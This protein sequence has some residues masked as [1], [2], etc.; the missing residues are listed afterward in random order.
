MLFDIG[1][2][3]LKIAVFDGF[4]LNLINLSEALDIIQGQNPDS[5]ACLLCKTG[6]HSIE[7][8]LK[9]AS[10]PVYTLN[11]KRLTSLLVS[12]YANW[13]SLGQDRIA[14]LSAA[15]DLYHP[16]P[17]LLI[18]VGTCI[19]IDFLSNGTFLGGNISP[20][21]AMRLKAMHEHTTSL[22]LLEPHKMEKALGNSTQ[23]AMQIGAYQSIKA[24]ILYYVD[25]FQKNFEGGRVILS[26]GDASLF[27]LQTDWTIF[28]D[29]DLIWKGML[30]IAR[31]NE[32]I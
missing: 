11:D 22:P 29:S 4:N 3:R 19:T 5:L 30:A 7:D 18:D 31:W 8:V 12:K 2:T 13:E 9:S 23:E 28:A 10:F 16:Q 32:L 14:L 27:D 26:G 21:W 6:S 24:E 1:N 15:Y 17:V 20:G 25:Y